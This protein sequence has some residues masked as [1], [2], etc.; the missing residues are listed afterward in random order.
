MTF[1]FQIKPT[2]R[3][4]RWAACAMTALA[5]TPLWAAEKV[6]VI[7]WWTSASETAAV[8]KFK[9][10]AVRRGLEWDDLAVGGGDS[11]R[12]LLKTRVAKGDPPT[13]AQINGA[14]RSYAANPDIVA[15]LDAVAAQGKWDEV[16]PEPVRRYARLGTKSYVAVPVNVHRQNVMWIST[17]A[18]KRIGATAAPKTWDE[19][20]AMADKAKAAG[21]QPLAMGEDIWVNFTFMQVAFTTHK[22]DEYRKAFYDGDEAQLKGAGMVKAFEVMRRL[23][24]YVDRSASTRKWNEATQMVIQ[25]RAFAQ[26]MG[27]WAKGEFTVAGKR[28]GADYLCATVPGSGRGHVFT[29]D[30]FL[31][32]KV[33]QNAKAQADLAQVFM[34][35]DAQVAFSLAKGSVPVRTDADVSKFDDCAKQSHADLVAGGKDGTAVATPNLFQSPAR[36]GAWR[37]VVL[38]FWNDDSITP[39]Q[40]ALSFAN[41]AKANR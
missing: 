28:Q 6:E 29:S 13:A 27:D 15:N 34:D 23:R 26:V 36:I 16:L 33:A 40:A 4:T 20:F 17:E 12:I 25:G 30:A 11:Q 18:M 19:F 37:D 1:P 9:E 22:P 14:V 10:A 38:S 2:Q 5:T 41:A 39:Q 24:G 32:F 31:F 7:H 21:I 3:V 35:K 8:A